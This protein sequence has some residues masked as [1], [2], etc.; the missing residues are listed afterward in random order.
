MTTDTD[1]DAEEG[2]EE[3]GSLKEEE[4]E[5]VTKEKMTFQ[6]YVL[7][8]PLLFGD[9]RNAINDD[10]PRCYEDLIDYEAV[11]H[12]LQEVHMHQFLPRI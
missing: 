4:A 8:D 2:S 9:F 7:R 6:E 11:Y 3:G 10:D 1:V 5:H 12:L